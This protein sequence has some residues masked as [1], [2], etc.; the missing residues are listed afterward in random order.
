V[1]FIH[2]KGHERDNSA[3]GRWNDVADR[4]CALGVAVD[5][6][7]PAAAFDPSRGRWKLSELLAGGPF[8]NRRSSIT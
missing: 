7:V 1:R 8:P 4:L 2:I 5:E 6:T 3:L